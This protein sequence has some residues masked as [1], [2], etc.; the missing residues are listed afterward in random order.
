MGDQYID[1]NGYK[2]Y[3]DNER[4]VH[5]HIAEKYIYKPNREQYPLPFS[6]YQ[7]H[8]KNGNKQYN[9]SNNLEVLTDS[10]HR[11]AHRRENDDGWDVY[12][13]QEEDDFSVE[14]PVEVPPLFSNF[15]RYIIVIT[16]IA[17]VI[18]LIAY[19]I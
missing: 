6:E 2:R 13:H 4:L 12:G 16:L 8:H 5:R 17:V 9:W 14:Y 19:S 3:S 10:E 15:A 11:R 7:V 1:E 18:G